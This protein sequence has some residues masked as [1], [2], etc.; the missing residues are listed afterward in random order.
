[1]K[2]WPFSICVG[3]LFIFAISF[4]NEYKIL[5]SM[6]N[7]LLDS[8]LPYLV[9]DMNLAAWGRKEIEVSEH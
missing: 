7:R 8:K 9:A 1:M 3:F 4:K 6:D 2:S 5:K